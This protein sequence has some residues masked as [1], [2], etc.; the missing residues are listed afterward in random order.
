MITA[1][2]A[3]TRH[4]ELHRTPLHASRSCRSAILLALVLATSWATPAVVYRRGMTNAW[5]VEQHLKSPTP[6]A[7]ASFGASVAIDGLRLVVGSPSEDVHGFAYV[8][9][10][11]ASGWART[12]TLLGSRVPQSQMFGSSVALDGDTVAVSDRYDANRG[13]DV[14]PPTDPTR[15][16]AASGAAYVF[17]RSS[18]GQWSE[19]AFIKAHS[20]THL[21]GEPGVRLA[22][23]DDTL[24]IGFPAED[25]TTTGVGSTSDATP[26]SAETNTGAVFIY[27]R[28]GAAWHFA[29]YIKSP[30]GDEDARF[31]F[32]VA[33]SG[34]WLL[35]GAPYE[36]SLGTSVSEAPPVLDAASIWSGTGYLFAH[37][38]P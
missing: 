26:S 23:D 35:V 21:D 19:Q 14:N 33:L 8:F 20:S 9:E 5:D 12:A 31:G 32:G 13:I 37:V 18:S 17:V 34:P 11:G 4:I 6:K 38:P 1:V 7:E 36:I 28:T 22:L 16:N 24:A 27:A 10:R 2:R 3:P 30:V 15:D 25:G 29:E